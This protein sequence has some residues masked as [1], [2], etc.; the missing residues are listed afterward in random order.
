MKNIFACTSSERTERPTKFAI[1]LFVGYCVIIRPGEYKLPAKV[2][3][4][5]RRG[6]F[7]PEMQL[8]DFKINPDSD[9]NISFNIK[10]VESHLSYRTREFDFQ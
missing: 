1:S 9:I 2:K 5:L 4:L 7:S 8:Q 10:V 6:L 3:K